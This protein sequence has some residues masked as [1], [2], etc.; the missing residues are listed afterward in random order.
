MPVDYSKFDKIGDDSDEEKPKASS[1]PTA[2]QRAE[3]AARAAMA[4]SSDDPRAEIDKLKAAKRA[5]REAREAREAAEGGSKPEEEETAPSAPV[6]VASTEAEP[7]LLL[8][9]AEGIQLEIKSGMSTAEAA[10]IAGEKVDV[11]EIST[12]NGLIGKLQIA[13]DSIS[14]GDLEEGEERDAARARRKVLNAFVEDV[15][16]EVQALRKKVL[17]S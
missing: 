8:R 2:E 7:L 15:M 1:G 5:A 6:N 12:L 14:I 17:A 13:I 9:K 4:S 3:A 11:S 16:P 10:L